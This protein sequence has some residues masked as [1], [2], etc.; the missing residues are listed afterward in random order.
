VAGV[1]RLGIARI[2]VVECRQRHSASGVRVRLVYDQKDDESGDNS[3]K[4]I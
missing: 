3:L 1:S 2:R 4:K